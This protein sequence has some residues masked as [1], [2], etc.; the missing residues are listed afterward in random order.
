M[1]YVHGES[2]YCESMFPPFSSEITCSILAAAEPLAKA[3][4]R[5]ERNSSSCA[6][7]SSAVKVARHEAG[8]DLKIPKDAGKIECV[9][10]Y[11]CT[12]C[13]DRAAPTQW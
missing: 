4:Y 5:Y 9:R 10:V 7:F 13:T 1:I 3:G 12:E 6:M 8:L 2:I 11:V